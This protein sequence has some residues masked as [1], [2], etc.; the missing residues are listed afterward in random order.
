M[1]YLLFAGVLWPSMDSHCVLS[2]SLFFTHW[3]TYNCLLLP[4]VPPP[5]QTICQSQVVLPSNS[6]CPP[7]KKKK[8][9]LGFFP[10]KCPVTGIH[11]DSPCVQGGAWEFF[12]FKSR[13]WWLHGR[14]LGPATPGSDPRGEPPGT[15]YSSHLLLCSSVVRACWAAP[16]GR[17]ATCWPPPRSA[18]WL[19]ASD[20]H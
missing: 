5:S 12:F 15:P 6:P 7:F 20:G 13:W 4:E 19:C 16:G 18:W 11:G 2:L 9:Q 10:R 1:L 8:T 3:A 14:R 17:P